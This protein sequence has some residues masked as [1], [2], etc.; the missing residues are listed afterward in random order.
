MLTSTAAPAQSPLPPE[1]VLVSNQRTA[2]TYAEFEAELARIPG[3]DQLEFLMD[4]TRLARLVE[5]VLINKTLALEARER[6]L[7]LLPKAQAEISVQTDKILAKYR[8]LQVQKEA[9]KIDFLARARET[10]LAYPERTTLPERYEVWH[11]LVNTKDRTPEQAKARAEDIRRRLLA[12]EA[13]EALAQTLSDDPSAA[14][15]KGAL[16]AR[17]LSK[18]IPRF[19]EEVKKLK[20]GEVSPAFE[21]SYGIHIAQLLGHIPA[22][23]YSFDEAKLA[24][25]E[26]AEIQYLRSVWADYIERIQNDPKLFVDTQALDALR[27]K[28][29]E[30]PKQLPPTPAAIEAVK[31][32]T[33]K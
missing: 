4:K 3:D 23:R 1:K 5:N 16:G 31:A 2:V 19:A 27:P 13:R 11:A 25:V 33:V 22:K 7:D 29:P 30:I 8:G 20:I 14:Q 12:G 9:P 28:L 21:T 6:K 32:G 10:Y 26:E 15:N 24:L 17:E 18:F